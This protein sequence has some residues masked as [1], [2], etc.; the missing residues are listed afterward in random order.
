MVVPPILMPSPSAATS[1]GSLPRMLSYFSRWARTSG[2]VR[3]LTATISMSWPL[4]AA[5]RQKLRPI[6]PNPLM[7]TRTVT[8]DLP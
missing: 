6:R 3:S 1:S 5:A 2:L 7:P 8:A 4:A